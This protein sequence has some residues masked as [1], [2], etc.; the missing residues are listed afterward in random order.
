M[1]LVFVC[2]HII[3]Q[4]G[5]TVASHYYDTAGVRKK[6]HNIQTIELSSIN[7]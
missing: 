3:V 1:L 4:T 5:T 7:F 6:Y 2:A